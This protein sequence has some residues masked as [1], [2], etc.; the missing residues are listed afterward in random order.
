VF[1]LAVLIIRS[2]FSSGLSIS[3]MKADPSIL[4]RLD[5]ETKAPYWPVGVSGQ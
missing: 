5:A 3:I 1:H 4:Q 2:H